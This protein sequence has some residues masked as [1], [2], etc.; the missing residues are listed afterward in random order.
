MRNPAFTPDGANGPATFGY[1]GFATGNPNLRPE[2]AD[3]WNVGAVI[4]PRFLPGFNATIDWWDIRLKGAVSRIGAQAIVDSCI[5][6]GDPIFCSRIHRDSRGSLLLGDGFVDN[7]QVD[8]AS[9]KVE[10]LNG[11]VLLSGFAKNG[12]ERIAAETIARN[13]SGV[14][15]VRNEIIVRP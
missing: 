2:E 11:T 14:R 3:S 8:A 12:N 6:T 13:T 4:S 5:A 7:R 9:I 10:T 15:N 1:S